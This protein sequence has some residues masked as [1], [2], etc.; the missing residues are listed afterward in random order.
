MV[1]CL[2]L[3]ISVKI[4]RVQFSPDAV[5]DRRGN[6]VPPWLLTRG[7]VGA[8]STGR[9]WTSRVTSSAVY[10]VLN[11]RKGRRTAEPGVRPAPALEGRA[12]SL[13]YRPPLMLSLYTHLTLPT[14]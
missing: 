13:N 6:C 5:V 8:A 9:R 10:G 11:V 3:Q 12:F 1:S 2:S 14:N 7:P 4:I